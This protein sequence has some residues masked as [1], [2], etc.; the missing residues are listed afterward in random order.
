MGLCSGTGEVKFRRIKSFAGI[1]LNFQ[2]RALR[3]TDQLIE[4]DVSWTAPY[5][6]EINVPRAFNLLRDSVIRPILFGLALCRAGNRFSKDDEYGTVLRD[7][8]NR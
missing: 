3:P 1:V 8:S 4:S 2:L 5:R 6:I 7:F